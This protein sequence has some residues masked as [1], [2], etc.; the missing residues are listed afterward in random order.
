RK[1][2]DLRH[3]ESPPPHARV[4]GGE[5]GDEIPRRRDPSRRDGRRKDFA[6]R[7]LRP[8]GDLLSLRPGRVPRDRRSLAEV[9][10]FLA[11]R[12]SQGGSATMGF[13]ARL[14]QRTGCLSV[15]ARLGGETR[16]E[17]I[18]WSSKW[19]RR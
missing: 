14:A 5:P 10:R 17:E 7:A 6:L 13:A 16:Q 19:L 11:Q 15:R 9:V 12:K 8:V 3:L 2:A 18:K 4:H 1:H